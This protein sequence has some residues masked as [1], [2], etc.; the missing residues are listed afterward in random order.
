MLDE[1]EPKGVTMRE[2]GLA[3]RFN[4]AHKQQETLADFMALYNVP[5]E[6]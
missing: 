2:V 4:T 3:T 5:H 1:G 6:F